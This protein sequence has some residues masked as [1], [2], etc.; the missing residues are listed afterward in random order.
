[1]HSAF[2]LDFADLSLRVV[3]TS[4]HIATGASL[5]PRTIWTNTHRHTQAHSSQENATARSRRIAQSLDPDQD[6]NVK[7]RSQRPSRPTRSRNSSRRNGPEYEVQP[8][9]NV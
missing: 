7:P 5:S 9:Q 3:D 2:T 6:L 4:I 1:M 8:K